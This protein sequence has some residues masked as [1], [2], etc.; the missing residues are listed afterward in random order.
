MK[1]DC[2]FFDLWK[3]YRSGRWHGINNPKFK[4]IDKWE[5]DFYN[6]LITYAKKTLSEEEIMPSDKAYKEEVNND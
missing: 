3:A 4:D 5:G 1:I 2:N 6:W